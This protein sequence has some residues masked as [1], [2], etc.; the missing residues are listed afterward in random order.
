LNGGRAVLFTSHYSLGSGFDQAVIEVLSLPDGRRKVLQ[1]GATY[2]RYM[3]TENGRGYLLYL[4]RG[5]LF[6]VPFD[7][8]RLEVRGTP[9]PVLDKVAYDVTSGAAHF[10][11]ARNGTMIYRA[12]GVIGGSMTVQWL[13]QA[14]RSRPILAKPGEYERPR[15]SPD[16]NQVAGAS[17][18][19]I[20]VYDSR[21]E[22]LTPLTF[23]GGT[24]SNTNP[25]WTPDGRFILFQAQGAIAWTRADGASRQQPLISNNTGAQLPWSFSDDGKRLAFMEVTEKRGYDLWTV[26]VENTGAGLRAGKPEP[27]LRESYDERHPSFSPDGKWLAYSSNEPG[28]FEVFVRAFPDRGGRWRVSDGGGVYPVWSRNGRELFYRTEDQRIMVAGYTV[29]G[30]S[31]VSDRPRVWTEKRLANVGIQPN[32][33]LAPDGKTVAAVMAAESPAGAKLAAHVTFLFNFG[34]EIRRRLGEAK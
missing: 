1:R 13:D 5:T 25:I 3:S 29:K 21:R 7:V 18:G 20:W 16:G 26:P 30:D 15:V 33:D 32:Y 19:D 31:F 14:G 4:T 28:P 9:S 8:N 22:A 17:Q 11:F 27:F 34:D 23:G 2:G 24:A 12:G 10:D 6:A